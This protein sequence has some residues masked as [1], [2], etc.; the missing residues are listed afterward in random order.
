MDSPPNPPASSNSAA[1]LIIRNGRQK[2]TRRPLRVPVTILGS[3]KGCDIRLNV[4]TVRPVHCMISLSTEG[5]Y[6]RSWG[7][8]DT[9]V[10]DKPATSRLLRDADVI[11]IGQFE[12]EIRWSVPLAQAVPDTGS[13]SSTSLLGAANEDALKLLLKQLGEARASFRR[14]KAEREADL[15]RQIHHFAEFRDDLERRES[16]TERERSRLQRLRKRFIAR[17]KKHWSTQRLKIQAE[18][19]QLET[20]RASLEASRSAWAQE[21]DQLRGRAEVEQREIERTWVQV[22]AAEKQGR[23][24]RSRLQAD[25]DQR[26]RA[27]A[28]AEIEL[29]EKR[30]ASF[31]ERMREEHRTAQLRIEAGGLE[32]RIVNRRAILLQLESQRDSA[33]AGDNHSPL[34]LPIAAEPPAAEDSDVSRAELKKLAGDL[35]DQRLALLEQIDQLATARERWREEEARIVEEMEELGEQ[36]RQR[37]NQVSERETAA[38]FEEENLDKERTALGQV[39][40]HVE[41]WQSRVKSRE[42]SWQA[43]SGRAELEH[44]R[45]SQLVDRREKAVGELYRRWSERRRQ[46]LQQLRAE[47]GRCEKQRK[48]WLEMQSGF[49]QRESYLRD[50]QRDVA[51]RSLI[52]E[53]ARQNLLQSVKDPA[54]AEKRLKWLD[55]HVRKSIARSEAELAAIQNAIG[56]ERT[57]LEELFRQTSERVDRAVVLEQ[58]LANHM[59]QTERREMTASLKE[60]RFHEMS[61]LW[62]S[63]RAL[64]ESERNEL[65]DEINR[66]AG[67]VIEAGA[68]EPVPLARAA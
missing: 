9:Q 48:A 46:E 57:A 13:K 16:E 17:W 64:Y 65:H 7:A 31:A 29:E 27:I 66:L 38:A 14:E 24:E 37:E 61:S 34:S 26:E 58:E 55:S 21:S 59:A 54:L 30:E 68:A 47:H 3:A 42:V 10:N 41:L 15:A 50:L 36:L 8:D 11:R 28:D 49:E 60:S 35:A 2:G 6:L 33:V 5:P 39:R 12:F 18:A 23:M 25:L 32:S 20:S 19:R 22:R 52:L 53:Q 4:N 51:A 43:E 62:N 40:E 44:Q 45:R 63:Q 67:M 1:E 56:E